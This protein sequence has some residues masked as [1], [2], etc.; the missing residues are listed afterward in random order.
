MKAKVPRNFKLL[1]MDLYDRMSDP[2]HHLSNFRSIMY[3]ANASNATRCKAF[4]ATLTKATMKWFDNLPPRLIA[5][6]DDLAK[7]FL[8]RFSIHK[9]KTKNAPSLLGVKQKVGKS[10]Q[11]T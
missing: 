5:C 9:D 3:L 7:K 10:L 4:P 11:T 1:D 2:S 6:F 8:T